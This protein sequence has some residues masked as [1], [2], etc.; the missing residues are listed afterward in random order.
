MAHK[1][2]YLVSLGCPK[3]QVDSEVMMGLLLR[4]GWTPAEGPEEADLIVVNTCAFLQEAVSE[5][6]ETIL[7]MAELRREGASLVVAGCL[8]QR[9]G[10][11][12]AK[13]LPEVDLWLGPGD[14][15]KLPQLLRRRRGFFVGDPNAFLYDRHSPRVLFNSPFVAYVKI[16]EG[17]SHRCTFCIIPRLRGRYRSRDP[18]DVLEEVRALAAQGVKEVVLVAQDTT[19][20]GRDL[21]LE[22]GLEALLRRLLEVPGYRWLRFLYT[23]PHPQDLPQGL[24]E[25]LAEGGRLVPYLDLPIQHVSDKVLERMQRRTSGKDIRGLV[26]TLKARWPQ[27][28]LRA[29]VMVGFPGEGE[30]EFRELMD[31]VAWAEFTHLGVFRF[32]AEEGTEAAEMADQVPP[33]VAEERYRRLMELQQGISWRKNLEWV[34]REVEVLVEGATEEG[35]P[36]GRTPFQAPEIDG[37]TI[38]EGPGKPG[39]VIPVEITEAGPYDLRGRS[40]LSR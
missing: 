18:E 12:V 28:A 26:E 40:K 15:P 4:E 34:G 16:A 23:Y 1:K 30:G 9:Y 36:V 38:V 19:A 21:G 7:E 22:G 17:C 37:V 6:V 27:I 35:Q 10:E 8:P 24:L 13:E 3:N 32:S 29:T 11:E 25:L 5:A 14:I 20:Y 31:F 33:E 2:V 39:E